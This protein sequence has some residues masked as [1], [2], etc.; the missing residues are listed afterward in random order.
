[1]YINKCYD[2]TVWNYLMLLFFPSMFTLKMVFA[3]LTQ[4]AWL[5]Y[6]N[7]KY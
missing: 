4:N 5:A 7:K 2:Y 3:A 6:N 1:M